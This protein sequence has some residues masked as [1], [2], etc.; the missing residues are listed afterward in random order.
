MTA[1]PAIAGKRPILVATDGT[2]AERELILRALP[3]ARFFDPIF[4]P[5]CRTS[6]VDGVLPGL[7][8]QLGLSC[9]ETV[10][11]TL[12]STFSATIGEFVEDGACRG[13]PGKAEMLPA[14]VNA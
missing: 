10:Y 3:T 8:V 13:E 9:A 1:L 4:P 5:H 12:G 6:N 11:T 7:V 2:E 14:N